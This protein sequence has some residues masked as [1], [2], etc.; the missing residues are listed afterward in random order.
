MDNSTRSTIGVD[1]VMVEHNDNVERG[2]EE[3]E[4]EIEECVV[5]SILQG[6][7]HTTSALV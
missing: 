6:L 1:K 5:T 4:R 3:F 2:E 7:C